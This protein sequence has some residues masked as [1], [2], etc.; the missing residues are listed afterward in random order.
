MKNGETTLTTSVS[1]TSTGSNW[2]N[3]VSNCK[4]ELTTSI[5]NNIIYGL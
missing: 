2:N 3:C 1:C 4:S 5:V